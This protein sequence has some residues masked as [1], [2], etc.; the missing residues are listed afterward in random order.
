[1]MTSG[2]HAVEAKSI[3]QSLRLNDVIGDATAERYAATMEA[4]LEDAQANAIL[5]MNCPTAL[6]S[7]Q[8]ESRPKW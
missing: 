3:G 5:V 8:A 2:M 7:A 4:V 6:A 1:M